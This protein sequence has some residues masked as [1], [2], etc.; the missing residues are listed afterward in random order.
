MNI[1]HPTSFLMD[2]ERSG[3]NGKENFST[4]RVNEKKKADGGSKKRRTERFLVVVDEKRASP[5]YVPTRNLCLERIRKA[6]GSS[7]QIDYDARDDDWL[8]LL[9]FLGRRELRSVVFRGCETFPASI[10]FLLP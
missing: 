3:M 5:L 6:K 1:G 7:P 4:C 8:F 10:G 2:V 9:H